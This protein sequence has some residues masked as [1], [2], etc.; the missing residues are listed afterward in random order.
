[1][2]RFL[3]FLFFIS[4]P[5]IGIVFAGFKIYIETWADGF[6]ISERGPC[7]KLLFVR[8]I[9]KFI[10]T[11]IIKSKQKQKMYH[12]LLLRL[13]SLLTVCLVII[14]LKLA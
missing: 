6:L 13:T 8:H 1:M 5:E 3:F 10:E 2:S 11:N 9:F 12:C 4:L 14:Y 7:L